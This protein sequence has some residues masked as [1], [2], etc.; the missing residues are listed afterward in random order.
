LETISTTG[1]SQAAFRLQQSTYPHL[2]LKAKKTSVDLKVLLDFTKNAAD[3]HLNCNISN[4]EFN[5]IKINSDILFKGKISEDQDKITGKLNIPKLQLN[6]YYFNDFSSDV[7]LST[8]SVYIK[9]MENKN[10]LSGEAAYNFKTKDISSDI[11][12][13]KADLSGHLRILKASW[14]LQLR[15][16]AHC[17]I[18]ILK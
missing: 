6:D 15:Q 3:S 7:N 14:I 13:S 16:A 1:L 10:G 11:Q 4:F 2:L 18:Q 17:Q 5:G 8:T 12:I 9:N